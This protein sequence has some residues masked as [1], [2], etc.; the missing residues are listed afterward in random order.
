MCSLHK[1]DM[2]TWNLQ[3]VDAYIM[4][5][6]KQRYMKGRRWVCY[7][8]FLYTSNILF[9]LQTIKAKSLFTVTISKNAL[10]KI[11][12]M[13][14]FWLYDARKYSVCL[15]IIEKE[16]TCACH[17]KR[18]IMYHIFTVIYCHVGNNMHSNSLSY[19]RVS[20]SVGETTGTVRETVKVS[21]TGCVMQHFL[22]LPW[23]A[24]H[25]C[26]HR[27]YQKSYCQVI[28]Y[29]SPQL[30]MTCKHLNTREFHMFGVDEPK[31][32]LW[33]KNTHKQGVDV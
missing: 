8:L 16:H 9:N 5:L 26:P 7:R 28:C 30:E 15:D 20:L 23:I 25:F 14:H 1:S 33:K 10:I 13:T 18:Y 21:Q 29:L 4:Y 27:E 22:I 2:E 24:S 11:F 3:R 17:I 31:R 12:L 32:P 6:V 19:Q